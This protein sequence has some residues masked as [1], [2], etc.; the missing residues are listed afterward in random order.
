MQTDDSRLE[1]GNED[2]E[3]DDFV[4]DD[5]ESVYTEDGEVSDA[6]DGDLD[7]AINM[8][9]HPARATFQSISHSGS[10]STSPRSIRQASST[11][12]RR[13][14]SSSQLFMSDLEGKPFLPPRLPSWEDLGFVAGDEAP[15]AP[16]IAQA[17]A[18]V[19]E[20]I[21]D[22]LALFSRR[23]NRDRPPINLRLASAVLQDEEIRDAL[24]SAIRNGL[25]RK[26]SLADGS[27]HWTIGP[28]R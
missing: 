4:V 1:S 10:S 19:V 15:E 23:V 5:D 28:R 16:L 9:R 21:I 6:F 11:S 20:E 13:R 3:M 24:E 27:K 14:R 17:S 8:V 22:A 7:L 2:Y 12:D 26:L 25:G 18:E